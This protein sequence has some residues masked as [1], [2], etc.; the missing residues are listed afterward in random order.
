LIFRLHQR[1]Y[2]FNMQI[3]F[4][5][6]AA[7]VAAMA[8]KNGEVACNNIVVDSEILKNLKSVLHPRSLPYV[9]VNPRVETLHMELKT[10]Y[11]KCVVWLEV[12]NL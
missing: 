12:V 4:Q 9:T 6:I 2:Y 5:I 11:P 3:F 8:V 1:F 10:S 7:G